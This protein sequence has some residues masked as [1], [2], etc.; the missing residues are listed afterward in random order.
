MMSLKVG[1]MI[2]VIIF[3]GLVF[4]DFKVMANDEM[5][6]IWIHGPSIVDCDEP[7]TIEI[8][9]WDEYE[10][11]SKNFE[12]DISLEY[13]AYEI[14]PNF[15]S[16][17][18]PNI[19]L[20]TTQL[21]FKPEDNGKVSLNCSINTEGLYYIKVIV[22]ESDSVYRSNP[23][24]VK[25][26]SLLSNEMKYIYWGDIHAHSLFS[27]GS[28]TPET[29]Y[30]YARDEALLDFAALT[31][32]GEMFPQFG[33][34][35][36]FNRLQEYISITNSFNDNGDFITLN[37]IEWTPLVAP[38]RPYLAIQHMNFYFPNITFPF[39]STF[40]YFTPDEV[41]NFLNNEG[42]EGDYLA[43]THHTTREDYG[44][45]YSFYDSEIN[46]MIEI[47]SCHGSSEF[48]GDRNL[49]PQIH[50]TTRSG[51]SINDGLKMGLKMGFMAS[52]DTHDGRLGH[53]L[54]H[55]EMRSV[56][57]DPLTLSAF[58]YGVEYHGSLTAIMAPE[59][60]RE[61][62]WNGLKTR[63]GYATT[64]VN[65]HLIDFSINGIPVGVENSTIYVPN[66]TSARELSMFVAV[67]G[68]S[69]KANDIVK[70]NRIEVFKNS[71]IFLNE[72]IN[73]IAY[74][75][76]IID[77]SDIVGASYDNCILGD[78]GNYYIHEKSLNPVDPATLNTNGSDYYYIRVTDTNGGAAWCGPLW[79]EPLA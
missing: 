40:Q 39:F 65:R 72:T 47:Y 76:I 9:S 6:S 35:V 15:V 43:W 58:R 25:N 70:I 31:D 29:S 18:N 60:S 52:S 64:W 12:G 44:S 32:H 21:S 75:N 27:D 34:K 38:A 11:I 42:Y 41:Y 1:L 8:E 28:G 66:K 61:S 56:N 30:K 69:L 14:F 46:T 57:E 49:Y 5:N 33:D 13:E 24:W 19:Q 45:D 79:V 3:W 22:S 62:I 2:G 23:I 10:R 37:A 63:S 77:D 4:L 51:M 71:E 48:I 16:I 67:D 20:E 36:L 55:N 54:L 73:E 26:K 50:E 74:S 78:D 53:S 17:S 68:V 59:L 7:F